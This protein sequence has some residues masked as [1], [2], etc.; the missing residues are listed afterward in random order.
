MESPAGGQIHGITRRA[1]SIQCHCAVSFSVHPH[2][3]GNAG[4]RGTARS[5]VPSHVQM[6]VLGLDRNCCI[7]AGFATAKWPRCSC[8]SAGSW[9]SPFCSAKHSAEAPSSAARLNTQCCYSV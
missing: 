2:I 1:F 9:L 3:T 5:V 7:T 8:Y 4:P 6:T